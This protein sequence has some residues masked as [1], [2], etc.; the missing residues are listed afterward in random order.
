MVRVAG[1]FPEGVSVDEIG[2]EPEIDLPRRTL[3]R[4]LAKLV[5]E[6]RLTIDG[7][8]RGS[9]YRIPQIEGTIRPS[10]GTLTNEGHT[11]SAETYIRI[12][13]EGETIKQAVRSPIQERQPVGYN[14]EFLDGYRPNETFYLPVDVRERL[15]QMGGFP[16]GNCPAGTYAQQIYHRLLI[17]LSWNSS[18][19]EGNTYS[20]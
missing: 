4:R 19:L 7:R 20:H 1:R 17:D 10:T 2:G 13:S 5:E 8:G 18:R 15:V 16:Q 3:Q 11:P 9:R 12:S 6:R 14:R